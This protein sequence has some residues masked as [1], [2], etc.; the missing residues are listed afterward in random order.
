MALYIGNV[1]HKFADVHDTV[2]MLLGI[3]KCTGSIGEHLNVIG[4]QMSIKLFLACSL[5][6]N[7]H[8]T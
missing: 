6:K 4:L 3:A 7:M 2:K 5:Y 8:S 1:V